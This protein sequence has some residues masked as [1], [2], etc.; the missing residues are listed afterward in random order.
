MCV[1]VVKTSEERGRQMGHTEFPLWGWSWNMAN[2]ILIKYDLSVPAP[3]CP[4]MTQFV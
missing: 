3:R 4:W 2:Y 1:F